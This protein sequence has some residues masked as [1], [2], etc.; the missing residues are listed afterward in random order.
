MDCCVFEKKTNIASNIKNF[1][2]NSNQG[3]ARYYK[4]K[5]Q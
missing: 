2:T 4:T 3:I 5:S 1:E